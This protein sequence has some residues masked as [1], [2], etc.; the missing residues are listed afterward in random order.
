MR[1]AA[2][3]LGRVRFL[4]AYAKHEVLLSSAAAWT[5]APSSPARKWPTRP[6][7]LT[8]SSSPWTDCLD[9]PGPSS[10]QS[11]GCVMI[12]SGDTGFAP[13]LAKLGSRGVRTAILAKRRSEGPKGKKGVIS[14]LLQQAA[15]VTFDWFNVIGGLEEEDDLVSNGSGS[16]NGRPISKASRLQLGRARTWS[17][18]EEL[19]PARG[20]E[21]GYPLEVA[22]GRWQDDI[23]N[24]EQRWRGEMAG[25]EKKLL[26][27]QHAAASAGHGRSGW[28]PRG[29]PDTPDKAPDV[30][31]LMAGGPLA[32][33]KHGV[34]LTLAL[35][36]PTGL[37]EFPWVYEDVMGRALDLSQHGISDLHEMS[38][39]MPD[40]VKLSTSKGA[41]SE[42]EADVALCLS[43]GAR[44]W[45]LTRLICSGLRRCLFQTLHDVPP[46]VKEQGMT[47]PQLVAALEAWAGQSLGWILREHGYSREAGLHCSKKMRLHT[48]LEDAGDLVE[49]ATRDGRH[50]YFLAKGATQDPP[51]SALGPAAYGAALLKRSDLEGLPMVPSGEAFGQSPAGKQEAGRYE[52]GLDE[53][54]TDAEGLDVTDRTDVESGCSSTG[55]PASYNVDGSAQTLLANGLTASISKANETSELQEMELDDSTSSDSETQGLP[56]RLVLQGCASD[57]DCRATSGHAPNII[58]DTRSTDGKPI[59]L[60]ER[61][62]YKMLDPYARARL[63]YEAGRT[64]ATFKSLYQQRFG[65]QLGSVAGFQSAAGLCR[66]MPHIVHEGLFEARGQLFLRDT[67]KNRRLVAG[68]RSGLRR[69]VYQLLSLQRQGLTEDSF[70]EVFSKATGRHLDDVLHEHGYKPGSCRK[71]LLDL[72]DLVEVSVDIDEATGKSIGFVTLATSAESPALTDGLL[73]YSAG[74]VQ[75]ALDQTTLPAE[76]LH[77]G[78]QSPMSTP[79]IDG[80]AVSRLRPDE[81]STALTEPEVG[82]HSHDQHLDEAPVVTD[83]A[84][85]IYEHAWH[86]LSGEGALSAA[87][88]DGTVREAAVGED[89]IET[90]RDLGP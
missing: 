50:V 25:L 10:P 63:Q 58:E 66:A 30:P 6:S 11:R 31:S 60:D 29:P 28:T 42:P 89:W 68:I 49:V 23:A 43:D 35:R 46:E 52:S 22:V 57:D 78:G 38:K 61:K 13:L 15:D 75:E 54:D 37:A 41:A 21:D 79:V 70:S 4:R 71:L 76:E 83:K 88:E 69:V 5:S 51:V 85:P 40:V 81:T 12:V 65:L 16:S 45:Q 34:R 77:S 1:E 17:A 64:E 36:G 24:A 74:Q 86:A 33:L 90:Q 18:E 2:R 19:P 48:L 84:A 56:G 14:A 62:S 80:S 47:L 26:Q 9:Q 55:G 73:M 82:G 53:D 72:C 27:V 44:N 20:W 7:S 87:L 39:Q 3:A 8:L 59:C 32:R 67:V